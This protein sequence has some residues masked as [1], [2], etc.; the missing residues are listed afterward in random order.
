MNDRAEL[1]FL[2]ANP[3]IRYLTQD[4]PDQ[5]A[6]SYRLFQRAADREL[7]L[8]TSEAVLIEVVR[9]LSSKML[10]SLPREEVRRHVTNVLQLPGL[11]VPQGKTF[12]DALDL[13]VDHNV[14]FVDALCV[15]QMRRLKIARIA[16]F[17]GHF[18]RVRDVT[19]L[20][21]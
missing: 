15:A 11:L 19:R 5:A 3:I 20:E 17:D 10:Y 14:D 16:S 21:P 12:R 9:V 2:D 6:C 13:W 18:D 7:R 1:V 8:I 4:N